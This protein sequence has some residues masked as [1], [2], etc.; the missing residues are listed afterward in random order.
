[1]T[2]PTGH[3][4]E[5]PLRWS[6]FDRFGHLNNVSYIEL[7]QEARLQFAQDTFVAAGKPIPAVFVRGI[8]ADYL[9]PILPDTTKVT[10]DTIVSHI[11]TT[12]FTTTQTVLDRHG[13]ACA[14]I[15]CVQVAV[16]LKTSRPRAIA[17]EELAV[18]ES[19]RPAAVEDEDGR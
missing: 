5:V 13:K 4:T 18:L 15:R 2:A 1:M 7:A 8:E 19:V 16:D 14:V 12:S 11:G 3:R 6:D 10:V 17:H 9:R